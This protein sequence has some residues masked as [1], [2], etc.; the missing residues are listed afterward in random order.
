MLMGVVVAAP[1]VSEGAEWLQDE[2]QEIEREAKEEVYK[3]MAETDREGKSKQICTR[4]CD[5]QMLLPG[6]LTLTIYQ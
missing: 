1:S 5:T 4:V 6:R 3:H 2:V